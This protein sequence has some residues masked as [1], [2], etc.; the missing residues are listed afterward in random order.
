MVRRFGI[1][2][3]RIEIIVD[4][5]CFSVLDYGG[6]GKFF[7]IVLLGRVLDFGVLLDMRIYL[8]DV[9]GGYNVMVFG[10]DVLVVFRRG[11]KI[12]RDGD[13]GKDFLI[14]GVIIF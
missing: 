4:L 8:G 10:D 11:G 1:F 3:D 9:R 13:V 7:F 5:F 2:V 6:G 14:D 12:G